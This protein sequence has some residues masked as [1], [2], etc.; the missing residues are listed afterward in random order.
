MT[1]ALIIENVCLPDCQGI[2]NSALSHARTDTGAKTMSFPVPFI[3]NAT[4]AAT[5]GL[6]GVNV[7]HT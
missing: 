7:H 5:D 1:D 3:H 4:A 6:T 2:F